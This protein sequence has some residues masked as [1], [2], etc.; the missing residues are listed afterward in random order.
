MLS[1]AWPSGGGTI[2][3]GVGGWGGVGGNLGGLLT[4]RHGTIYIKICI[5]LQV[6]IH[7]TRQ[8]T[9][10]QYYSTYIHIYV[11]VY[12]YIDIHI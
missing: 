5:Y 1:L 10:I 11:Y 8:Y 4:R 7:T 9:Y 3:W 12:T 2:P 6:S